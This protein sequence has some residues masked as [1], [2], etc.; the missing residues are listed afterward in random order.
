[1]MNIPLVDLKAQYRSIQ[2]EIDGVVAKVLASCA[3]IGGPY[4]KSFEENFA[5]YCGTKYC[6]GVGNGTDALFIALK[7][8]GIGTGDEVITAAN[9]FIA[10]SEAITMTG[11]RVVFADIDPATYN[12][13]VK[14]IERIVTAKTKA[15]IPVHL[16][17]QPVDLEPIVSLARKH[18][19]KVVGDAAQAHGAEYKGK[20]IASWA[21]ATCY[22]FYPGKNLGAYGEAGAVVT[23]NGNLVETMKMFRD[24]GQAK[25]YYH[26]M[27]G[28][29]A[30][31]DGFQGAVL[32][33]K[34]KYLPDWTEA[35]RK[36]A[37]L[38]NRLLSGIDGISTPVEA[39]YGK[40]VYHIYS[41]RTA[42]SDGMMQ[43]LKERDIASAM[44]YPVPL[45]LQ[46]AYEFLGYRKGD[47]PVAED[48]AYEQLSLP[49]YA[50]LSEEQIS[51]V[52]SAVKDIIS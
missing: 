11:A 21:D 9:S 46:D 50:E 13:D 5:A 16:Y 40:H 32:D 41:L 48:G 7:A 35:R 8:L 36:N 24:H 39:A 34:L 25:K 30:R 47:F 10:T 18:G 49:M 28:W 3:F 52:A 17:G 12:I 27:V 22:S 37:M 33:I 42:D 20:K 31:M 6:I 15:V 44:H 23:N 51:T 2:G 1:M 4:L 29:N 38:Y 26:S 14:D 45:H 43:A 19:M